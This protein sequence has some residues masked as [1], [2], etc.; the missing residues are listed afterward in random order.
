[1]FKVQ[2]DGLIHKY[3]CPFSIQNFSKPIPI[4]FMRAKFFETDTDTFFDTEIFRNRYRYFFRYQFFS[5]PIP[6]LFSI[7]DFFE[8]NTDTFFDTKIFR[9]Q[10]R[11]HQKKWKSFENEKF[12]NRN[13]TLWLEE[14]RV[15]G[16]DESL[17]PPK[18]LLIFHQ[19]TYHH[20]TVSF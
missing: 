18:Y 5:K 12:R 19:S 7:P 6:I 3:L 15:K 16:L 4:L 20:Y 8:T 17:G 10:Y 9:N 2:G 14:D 1:M 11:Y 13:V